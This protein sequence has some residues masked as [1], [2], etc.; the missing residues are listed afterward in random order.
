MLPELSSAI[1]VTSIV[2]RLQC[3]KLGDII[4]I[5][6]LIPLSG[7]RSSL[8]FGS[9]QPVLWCHV[10]DFHAG[11]FSIGY[12]S[13]SYST[14]ILQATSRIHVPGENRVNR[15]QCGGKRSL[16]LYNTV[17]IGCTKSYQ[18]YNLQPVFK[19]P[20]CHFLIEQCL[21]VTSKSYTGGNDLHWKVLGVNIECK[22]HHRIYIDSRYIA[23]QYNTVLHTAQ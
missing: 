20:K 4:Q 18:N 22:I 10:Q 9:S 16:K 23:V 19:M 15:W 21:E 1:N 17:V 2:F 8:G 11:G 12:K 14:G 7:S 5:A 6:L 13:T 3:G